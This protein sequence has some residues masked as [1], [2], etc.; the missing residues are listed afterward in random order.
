MTGGRGWF[1]RLDTTHGTCSAS[2]TTST[3]KSSCGFTLDAT[4]RGRPGRPVAATLRGRPRP[5][6]GPA[7]E[8]A[9]EVEAFPVAAGAGG[10]TLARFFL[11]MTSIS[12]LNSS[13]SSLSF[14]G[15]GASSTN[16]R[17][18]GLGDGPAETGGSSAFFWVA[19]RRESRVRIARGCRMV[20]VCCRSTDRVITVKTPSAM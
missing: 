9:A 4:L 16:S 20:T 5:G 13:S 11:G 18:V 1:R 19:E 12:T 7:A 14:V 15:A 8:G 17:F 10:L 2:W 3:D 6:P